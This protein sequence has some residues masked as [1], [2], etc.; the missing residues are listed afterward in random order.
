MRCR[1]RTIFTTHP[2]K[3]R[4]CRRAVLDVLRRRVLIE[5]RASYSLA[6]DA[7]DKCFYTGDKCHVGVQ[8]D[9]GGLEI[10][11]NFC[12]SHLGHVFYGE[13]QTATDERHCV[14]SICIKCVAAPP[15]SS[16]PSNAT[17][18][19]CPAC[20]VSARQC[21]MHAFTASSRPAQLSQRSRPRLAFA[22]HGAACTPTPSRTSLSIRYVKDAVPEG[23]KEAEVYLDPQIQE[24]KDKHCIL[25]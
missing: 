12:G 25:S 13:H 24:L 21:A 9:G 23:L 3:P 10:I 7:F 22:A 19:T 17:P 8:P 4:P 20:E 15:L 2:P 14:N 1:Q 5:P 16:V 18:C 11:C 6:G